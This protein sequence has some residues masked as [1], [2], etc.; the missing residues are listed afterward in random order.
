MVPQQPD[1]EKVFVNHA[2]IYPIAGIK[3]ATHVSKPA[4]CQPYNRVRQSCLQRGC[5]TICKPFYLESV[6]HGRNIHKK[7]TRISCD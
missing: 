7:F 3:P 6:D 5:P 4:T 2:N 1:P